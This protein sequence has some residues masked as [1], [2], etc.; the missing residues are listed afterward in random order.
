M[1]GY[2]DRPAQLV[3]RDVMYRCGDGFCQNGAF[4]ATF[5]CARLKM[6]RGGSLR[7]IWLF[8]DP[9]LTIRPCCPRNV[10]RVSASWNS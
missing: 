5:K 8:F 9:A 6:I 1:S 7:T 4:G 2:V 10:P 3:T